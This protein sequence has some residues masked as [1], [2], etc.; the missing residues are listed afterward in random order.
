MTKGSSISMQ[1]GTLQVPHDPIL[2][3]IEGDGTE[4][5]LAEADGATLFLLELDYADNG[6]PL[7]AP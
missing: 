6:D 5:D 7:T 4:S 1:S 2:P 3:F